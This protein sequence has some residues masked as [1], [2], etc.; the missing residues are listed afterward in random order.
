[1]G[2]N[3]CF[4]TGYH[5]RRAIY[6]I[7]PIQKSLTKYIKQNALEIEKYS[8]ENNIKTLKNNARELVVQGITSID[9]V[10]TLLSS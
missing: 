9:E 10:Y 8:V 6:E 2:C 4:H 1:M 7:L 5:G 3:A